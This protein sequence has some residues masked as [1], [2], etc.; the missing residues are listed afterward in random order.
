MTRGYIYDQGFAEER[1][2]ISGM[3]AL[4]D[5]GSRALLDE[6]GIDRRGGR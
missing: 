4:W 6:L 2:R 1:A 3:E 5:P